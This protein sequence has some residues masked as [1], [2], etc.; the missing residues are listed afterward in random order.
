MNLI[1]RIATLRVLG[2]IY[3]TFCGGIASIV[4]QR[5]RIQRA[6]QGRSKKCR[7]LW[8]CIARTGEMLGSQCDSE[9]LF[10]TDG[11]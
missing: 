9:T 1:R 6:G 4:F 10:S 2:G 8:A 7:N 5:E 3:W 11:V